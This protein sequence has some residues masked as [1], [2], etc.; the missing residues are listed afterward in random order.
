VGASASRDISQLAVATGLHRRDVA[1]ITA[2][3]RDASPRRLSPATQVLTLWLSDPG[4]RRAG[5]LLP[6]LPRQGAAPSFEAL[7]QAVTRHVHPRSLLDELARL[8]L[9]RLDVESDEVEMLKD[10]VVPDA[11]G[12]RLYVLLGANLGDHLSAAADNV[13]GNGPRH[14]EQAVFAEGMSAD[15]A[16]QADRLAREHW[17]GALKALAPQLQALI[18]ADREAG[19]PCDHRVRVGVYGYQDTLPEEHDG[20]QA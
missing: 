4:Y 18:E 19:R 8:G 20:A 14:L 1:R 7:A 5:Q 13:L 3:T 12:E 15:S 2:E 9:V 17:A 10:S 16:Q 11:H 6:R